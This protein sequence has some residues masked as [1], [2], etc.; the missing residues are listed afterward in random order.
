MKAT[1]VWDNHYTVQTQTELN[2]VT[3]I[4]VQ[5]EE[6]GG[7]EDNFESEG[8]GSSPVTSC[9]FKHRG[10]WNNS[11]VKRSY[12]IGCV[13]SNLSHNNHIDVSGVSLSDSQSQLAMEMYCFWRS[14][15]YLK[16]N[17]W[18]KLLIY[19][20]NRWCARGIRYIKPLYYSFHG[21]EW[22]EAATPVTNYLSSLTSVQEQTNDLAYIWPLISMLPLYNWWPIK[23]AS[24]PEYTS[25]MVY[26]TY[27]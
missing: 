19:R 12:N 10:L 6:T 2:E 5:L 22:G 24:A 4:K 13:H 21:T 25:L 17:S 7:K 23:R 8:L 27:T 18:Q 26:L 11:A 3:V 20:M 9:V 1:I 15:P 14:L 16:Q